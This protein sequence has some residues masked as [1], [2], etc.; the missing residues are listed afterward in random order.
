MKNLTLA[1]LHKINKSNKGEPCKLSSGTKGLGDK[2]PNYRDVGEK[3]D[4][5]N[6]KD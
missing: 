1:M 4:W 3:N 5:G 2:S 6:E